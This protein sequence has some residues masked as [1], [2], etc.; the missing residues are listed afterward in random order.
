MHEDAGCIALK[1]YWQVLCE[2]NAGAYPNLL[3]ETAGFGEVEGSNVVDNKEA[4]CLLVHPSA[5]CP[6]S[7]AAVV[8]FLFETDLGLS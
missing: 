7:T 6:L 3:I 2:D 8:S 4:D 5:H 1:L